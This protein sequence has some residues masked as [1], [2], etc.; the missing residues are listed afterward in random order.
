MQLYYDRG[1]A[2]SQLNGNIGGTVWR[3]KGDGEARSFGYGYDNVNRILKA[4]FTQYTDNSWNRT[5][6]LNFSMQMGNGVDAATAYDANGNIL[7]MQQWGAKLNSSS[8][9]DELQYNYYSGS[10]KLKNVIDLRNDTATRLGDFRSSKTYMD[11]LGN[12]KTVLATD[13]EYDL[14]GNLSFDKNKDISVISYN[15]LNLPYRVTVPNK[16]TITYIYDATGNKVEKRV[17]EGDKDTKT[18]YLSGF[19]YENNKLQFL[20]QE[21]GRIR[22]VYDSTGV[23][24]HYVYDYFVKDHLGNTRMVLTEEW[25]RQIYPAAT[26]EANAIETEKLYYQV[27]PAAVVPKPVSLNADY[28]NN[29]GIPNPGNQQPNANSTSMYRLNAATGD[30]MGLGIML[31]VMSGDTVSILGKSFWHNNAPCNIHVFP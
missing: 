12:Q 8:L 6:G 25:E 18:N 16:G 5:A 19:V 20:G 14:N 24:P 23:V 26:L 17:V 9:I 13:Y 4:D 30:K 31:K 22:A 11:Q 29:N 27:N 1:H 2:L 3:S 21:E 10:N 7:A 15:H 28:P